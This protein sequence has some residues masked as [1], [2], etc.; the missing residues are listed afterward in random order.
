MPF[1][2]LDSVHPADFEIPSADIAIVG[3]GA[4][5]ILLAVTLSKK[6][7]KVLMLES[8]HFGENEEKQK[9][10][11][12]RQTGKIV[13]NVV[14][15]RKRAIG[16][17]TIAWGGQSLPF[18]PLDFTRREWIENSGWPVSFDELAPYYDLANAFM[19][20]DGLNYNS[21]IFPN[22]L[23]TNP[24]I[25]PSI[26]DYHVSKWADQ[27]N[28]YTLYA[29]YL[30][31]N[32]TV[33][34]NAHLFSLNRNGEGNIDSIDISNFNKEIFPCRPNVVILAAGG[35]ET[36]RI[37]LN[38]WLGNHS[39]LL[40]KYFMEHPCIEIGR[41]VP[42]NQYS[43]QKYFNTHI[44]KR[45]K[46][47]IRLSLDGNFQRQNRLLNCSASIMFVSPSLAFDPYAELRSFKR[48]FK[49]NRLI[50]LAGS[51]PEI[52][53]GGLAYVKDRFY[54]KKNAVASLSL[55]AEQEPVRTS[56]IKLSEELDQF[57]LPKALINWDIS[58]KTWKTVVATAE[59]VKAELE[60]LEFG[61]VELYEHI[62]SGKDNWIDYLSDVNH[63][64]GGC[65]MSASPS[66]GV[67]NENLQVWN[68]PNLYV[69]S[70]SVFPTSSHSN[71]TLTLLALA[72]RLSCHLEKNQ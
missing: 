39:D 47:S 43:L 53:A 37:L 18:S 40:G 46:Y 27:P 14:W 49:L 36:T 48:D 23:L 15:G 1:I 35:I 59:A 30:A 38:N 61:S 71:P 62:R 24:G 69:C 9:L 6:G 25:N 70:S 4:A 63:H 51:S 20:I 55:M 34:Y 12:V 67:V 26:L 11:E 52:V 65:K 8:G 56:Y 10:N 58:S 64:M 19:G 3:A 68:V 17:T 57:G 44:W 22:I 32:V 16:G 2:N 72:M 54:Y 5:G 13:D 21:D 28:F 66:E 42:A 31:T 60:R 33:L 7:K 45:K 41:I 29:D 50:R